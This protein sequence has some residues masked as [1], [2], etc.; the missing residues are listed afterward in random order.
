MK[1]NNNKKEKLADKITEEA[2][3]KQKW[4]NEGGAPLEKKVSPKPKKFK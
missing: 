3:E 1:N 2:K 4:E